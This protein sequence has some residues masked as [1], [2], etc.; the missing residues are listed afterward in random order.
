MKRVT[1]S[2]DVTFIPVHDVPAST[3]MRHPAYDPASTT[4]RHPAHDPASATVYSDMI[5]TRC[6]TATTSLPLAMC[7]DGVLPPSAPRK[8]FPC[9]S[10]REKE[11]TKENRQCSKCKEDLPFALTR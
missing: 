6:P 5:P 9:I 4:V 10:C 1:F 2:P 3:T 11:V 7:Y 8:W